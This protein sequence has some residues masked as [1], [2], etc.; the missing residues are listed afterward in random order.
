MTRPSQKEVERRIAGA[1]LQARGIAGQ[2]VDGPEP[3]DV[4]VEAPGGTIGLEIT[5]YHRPGLTAAGRPRRVVEAAWEAIRAFVVTYRQSH[6]ELNKLSVRLEFTA[7]R[8]PATRE[9]ASFVEAV[10]DAIRVALSSLGEDRLKIKIDST[11]APMLKQ[12]LRAIGVRRVGSYMEWDWNHDFGGIGTSCAELCHLF[13]DKLRDYK[14]PAGLAESHLVI[15]GAGGNLSEVIGIRDIA[16]LQDCTPLNDRIE[17]SAF[18][19]VAILEFV[20]RSFLWRRGTGWSL[21]VT[22]QR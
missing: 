16:E 1:Y 5:S 9:V 3:P 4:I 6:P 22:T 18:D 14:P 8:V 7:L 10:A 11:S 12:Y 21:F 19:A 2:P 13:G 17:A 15:V 20:D